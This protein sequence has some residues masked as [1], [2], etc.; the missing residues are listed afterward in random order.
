MKA[1]E[2]LCHDHNYMVWFRGQGFAGCAKMESV[3]VD[4]VD[5]EAMEMKGQMMGQARG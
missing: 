1:L 4:V 2:E 5:I 3:T